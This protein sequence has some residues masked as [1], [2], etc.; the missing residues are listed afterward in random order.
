MF[1]YVG[2]H[3][4]WI[5]ACGSLKL[6]FGDSSHLSPLNSSRQGL[7]PNPELTD[8]SWSSGQLALGILPPLPSVS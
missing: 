8:F 1:V 2:T 5:Y 4:M 3:H 6:R 7:L